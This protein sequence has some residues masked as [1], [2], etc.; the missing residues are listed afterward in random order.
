M[1]IDSILSLPC[2]C[3]CALLCYSPE[4]ATYFT[5]CNACVLSW[6]IK[7]RSCTHWRQNRPYTV[8]FVASVYGPGDRVAGSWILISFDYSLGCYHVRDHW[9]SFVCH[10]C[11]MVWFFTARCTFVAIACRRT[12]YLSVRLS[13]T[14]VDCDHV[15]WNSSKIISRLVSLGRSLSADLKSWIYSKGS[16]R[17]FWPKVTCWFERR[18]HSI[19]N[20][21]RMVTDSVTVTMENL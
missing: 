18:R 2:V 12:V 8:D 17:K 10:W 21:G 4:S 9:I 19:A 20:C 7:S 13:V 15:G 5:Q 11:H 6:C 16:D 14:L 1:A 3:L